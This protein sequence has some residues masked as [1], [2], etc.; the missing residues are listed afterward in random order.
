MTTCA[1][2]PVSIRRDSPDGLCTGCRRRVKRGPSCSRPWWIKS[3]ANAQAWLA[4]DKDPIVVAVIGRP[5]DFV[6]A[7]PSV[8]DVARAMRMAEAA[9]VEFEWFGFG[10]P[11]ADTRAALE[12]LRAAA[13]AGKAA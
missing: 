5:R 4:G 11:A 6:P 9:V 7:P 2:C 10:L 8:D 13:A 1:R 3:A 12:V